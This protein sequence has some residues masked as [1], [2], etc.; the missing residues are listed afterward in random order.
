MSDYVA[1]ATHDTFIQHCYRAHHEEI[2]E[3]LGEAISSQDATKWHQAMNDEMSSL[4]ANDTYELVKLPEWHSAVGSR[5]VY[6]IKPGPNGKEKY[7]AR[8]VAKGYSQVKDIDY[9]ET[10]A[11][12]AKLTTLRTLLQVSA[13]LE[14]SIHQMD[15][16]TAYLNSEIDSEI[17]VKHPEG[18]EVMDND[19]N[20]LCC[21]LKR[22]LYRL[23]LSGSPW[24]NTIHNFFVSEG[25]KKSLSDHC[26]YVK[27]NSNYIVIVLIWVDDIIIAGNDDG[28][29]TELKCSFCNNFKMTDLGKLKWFLGISFRNGENLI[30]INQTRYVQ[31]ILDKLKMSYCH[32]VK[33][34]CDL[35]FRNVSSANS[36]ELADPKLYREIVGSLIYIMVGTRPDLSYIVTKLSQFMSNPTVCHLNAAKHVLRYS[37]GTLDFGLKFSKGSS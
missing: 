20:I 12:T 18:Y 5:W 23:K 29:I 33:I 10:F 34:P 1:N 26:L 27:Y 14:R 28:M 8:F 31:K 4:K 25:F 6:Q 11:P 37:N 32:P 30:E 19:G 22:S 17:Y 2:P 13:N 35:S 36:S 3:I 9:K 21:R 16:K 24:N 15:V 7:K